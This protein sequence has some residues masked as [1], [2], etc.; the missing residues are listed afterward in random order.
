[1]DYDGIMGVPITF[2][3]KYN[4]SQFEILGKSSDI[5]DMTE[6]RK[7]ANAQGGGPRFYVMK[8]EYQQECMNEL[9]SVV[10]SNLS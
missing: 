10:K 6:I 3:D 2:L 9:L 7:M 8:M 4:P 5:A 1:M